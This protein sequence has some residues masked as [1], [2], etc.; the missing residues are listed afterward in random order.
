MSFCTKMCS[1]P[2]MTVGEACC[3]QLR[4]QVALSRLS[5]INTAV[6]SDNPLLPAC[7]RLQA[8]MIRDV[9][10][11]NFYIKQRCDVWYRTF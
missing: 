9:L 10:M 11:S 4:S 7:C 6:N 3:N 2:L 5:E 8:V 1:G